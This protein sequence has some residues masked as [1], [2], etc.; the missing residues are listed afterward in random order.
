MGLF[1]LLG[2]KPSLEQALTTATAQLTAR[3]RIAEERAD[4]LVEE[5]RELAAEL[6]AERTRSSEVA[7]LRA[8][9]Q[10]LEETIAEAAAVANAR[11]SAMLDRPS[12]AFVEGSRRDREVLDSR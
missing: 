12:Y 10:A 11:I 9:I 8:R 2:R 7:Y 3:T 6:R 1:G 5:V 4:A